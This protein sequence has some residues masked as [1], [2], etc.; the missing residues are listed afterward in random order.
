MSFS[1]NIAA[2]GGLRGWAQ[3]HGFNRHAA[4]ALAREE[5]RAAQ[6]MELEATM[7]TPLVWRRC[8]WHGA[9]IGFR[10]ADASECAGAIT[11]TICQSCREKFFQE[12]KAA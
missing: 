7:A 1:K 12:V 2:R 10:A 11:D 9:V 5:V 8:A 3:G 4:L 6:A